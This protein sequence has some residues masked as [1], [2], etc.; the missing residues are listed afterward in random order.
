MSQIGGVYYILTELAV[1]WCTYEPRM[2][3]RLLLSLLNYDGTIFQI[4]GLV[5]ILFKTC[6]NW[7]ELTYNHIRLSNSCMHMSHVY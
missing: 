4:K 5:V 3:A 7:V 1:E 6:S 2:H